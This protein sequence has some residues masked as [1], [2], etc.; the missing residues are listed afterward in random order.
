[1]N[2]TKRLTGAKAGYDRRQA[3]ARDMYSMHRSPVRR[4]RRYRT[5]GATPSATGGEWKSRI[6]GRRPLKP[7]L[8]GIGFT[9]QDAPE[10]QCSGRSWTRVVD[11]YGPAVEVVRGLRKVEATVFSGAVAPTQ[12]ARTG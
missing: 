8:W 6:S 1:M 5:T 3:P 7:R 12:R 10:P 11:G 9:P 2:N 4:S